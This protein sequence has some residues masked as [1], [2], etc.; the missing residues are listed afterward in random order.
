M[1]SRISLAV[2]TL[3]VVMFVTGCL[4]VGGTQRSSINDREQLSRLV[5]IVTNES[6]YPVE[7]ATIGLLEAQ[8]FADTDEDGRFS[9]DGITPGTYTLLVGAEY[10]EFLRKPVTVAK[11]TNDVEFVLRFM[12]PT[13]DDTYYYYLKNNTDMNLRFEFP[14]QLQ[15][16]GPEMEFEPG[17]SFEISGPP[18]KYTFTILAE[19]S[20]SLFTAKGTIWLYKKFTDGEVVGG[21]DSWTWTVYTK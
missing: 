8:K 14:D 5:G 13:E 21:A 3:V 10:L 6:G 18:G 17:R 19:G 9:L 1:R 12:I 16:P 15:A 4:G 11:G 20:E 7:N 2:V